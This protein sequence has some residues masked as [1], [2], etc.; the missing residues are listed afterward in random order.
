[1]LSI[2]PSSNL[3]THRSPDNMPSPGKWTNEAEHDL[4]FA[5]ILGKEGGEKTRY[6]WP[7]VH[8]VMNACGHTFTKE[9]ISYVSCNCL[10]SEPRY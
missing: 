2:I 8:D 4:L 3:P 10:F 5:M 6:N 9:A 7:A 1:M